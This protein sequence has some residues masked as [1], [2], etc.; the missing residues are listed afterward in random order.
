[1]DSHM[2][3]VWTRGNLPTRTPRSHSTPPHIKKNFMVSSAEAVI[4]I[5][6]FLYLGQ[7]KAVMDSHMDLVWTRG[8]LPTRTPRSH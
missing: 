1:M 6:K 4:D 5:V 3:L 8:N 7:F 2:N